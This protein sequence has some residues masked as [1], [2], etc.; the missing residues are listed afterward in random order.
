MKVR[1]LIEELQGLDANL[2]V[3][4]SYNYGDHW[5]TMVASAVERVEEGRVKH[6]EYHS[7]DKFIDED[8]DYDSAVE[9]VVLRS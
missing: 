2:E 1:E 4:F 8:D 3:H 5:R 9:V 7:M 6:S